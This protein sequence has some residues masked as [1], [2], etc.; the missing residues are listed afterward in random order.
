MTG[1]IKMLGNNNFVRLN[2]D[3]HEKIGLEKGQ[4][5]VIAAAK[6]YPLSEEDP[7]TQRVM[8]F[9]Q[10]IVDGVL[11]INDKIFV[12]DPSSIDYVGDEENNALF[13]QV[14]TPAEDEADG[15]PD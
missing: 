2:T 5:L 6:A 9:T 1:K 10:K 3:K 8:F 14:F 13:V 7:Y 15:S 11:N 12:L 4:L